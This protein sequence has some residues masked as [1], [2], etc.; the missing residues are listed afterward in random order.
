M[1][2]GTG[3]DEVGKNWSC[4]FCRWGFIPSVLV[5]NKRVDGDKCKTGW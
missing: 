2:A 3:R 4:S 1:F 5:G